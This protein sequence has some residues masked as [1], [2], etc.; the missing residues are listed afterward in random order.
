MLDC[1]FTSNAD[2]YVSRPLLKYLQVCFQ[3]LMH[4]FPQCVLLQEV[5]VALDRSLSS[6]IAGGP[7]AAN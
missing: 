7:E 5:M 2:R 4:L 6:S 1:L 3:I